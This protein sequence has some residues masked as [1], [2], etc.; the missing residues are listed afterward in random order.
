LIVGAASI[1]S[2]LIGNALACEVWVLGGGITGITT[3]LALQA[4]GKKTAIISDYV[5]LQTVAPLCPGVATDFAMASAYPHNLRVRNLAGISDASQQAFAC[6]SKAMGTGVHRY[7]MYEVHE[8]EPDEAP[9]ASRRLNFQLFDGTPQS[10]AQT[11][12]PPARPGA[13]YLWGWAFDTYFADMPVYLDFLW[14][15]FKERGGS[16]CRARLD[17]NEI[18]DTSGERVIFNCLGAGA[19]DLVKDEASAVMVRGRQVLAPGAPPL[20]GDSGLPVAY[21]Y[22]PTA[23]VFSRADGAPEYVHF[24]SRSDVWVL[25]QT[26]EPGFLNHDG[27]WVGAAVLADEVRIGECQVPAPIIDLNDAILSSWAGC[28]VSDR[29]LVGRTGYRYYRDPQGDGVRLESETVGDAC[30]IHNYGHGGS[31]VTMSWG[32]AVESVRL[33]MEA[34]VALSPSVRRADELDRSIIDLCLG[35]RTLALAGT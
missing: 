32:C 24:F 7:Q 26:R 4:L 31:G 10:L 28:S 25:G 27:E 22:T 14:S 9:L 30:V 6:L 16:I 17:T 2:G 19:I 21:N 35:Q 18:F 33:M 34:G 5:P 15:R 20:V 29:M 12:R 23:E 13:K 8:H 3:A 1:P 11:I